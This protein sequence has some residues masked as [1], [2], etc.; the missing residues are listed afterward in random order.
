M[1][2]A[3]AEAARRV[4]FFARLEAGRLGFDE[5]DTPHLLLGFINV[6]GGMPICH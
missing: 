3:F 1:F 5:I 2:D 4:I 6:D